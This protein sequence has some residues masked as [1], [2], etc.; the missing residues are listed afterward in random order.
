MQQRKRSAYLLIA[1]FMGLFFNYPLLSAANR[2]LF[3]N[4]TP[5]LAWYL[6]GVWFLAI[7][8]LAVVTVYR[9]RTRRHE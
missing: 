4:D 1:V 7:F 5:V 8:F 2:L 3:I 6:F 9:K